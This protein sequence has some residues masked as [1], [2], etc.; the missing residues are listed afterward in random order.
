MA[1]CV[2]LAGMYTRIGTMQRR[3]ACP[4]SKD[5]KQTHEA[6]HIFFKDDPKVLEVDTGG[7]LYNNVNALNVTKLSIHLK[8]AGW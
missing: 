4:L 2:G 8:I 7:W 5:D 6:S 1:P 3:L